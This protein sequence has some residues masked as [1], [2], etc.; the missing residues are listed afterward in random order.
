MCVVHC[1]HVF[2]VYWHVSTS[3]ASLRDVTLS[4]RSTHQQCIV[5]VYILEAAI[6]DGGAVLIPHSKYP[7]PLLLFATCSLH[8]V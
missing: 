2:S 5:G 4:S 7:L 6:L 3:S 8:L 1:M